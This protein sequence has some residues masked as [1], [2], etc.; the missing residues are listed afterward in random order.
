MTRAPIPAGLK[1]AA[2]RALFWLL[3]AA[4]M[5]VLVLAVARSQPIQ[6]ST[7]TPCPGQP[8]PVVA[9]QDDH[10]TTPWDG[11]SFCP[12][13][14]GCPSRAQ[15]VGVSS[16]VVVAERGPAAVWRDPGGVVACFRR[17]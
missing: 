6:P 17:P 7:D 5:L 10:H 3:I 1:D 14:R 15:G 12:D 4:V 2:W 11:W 8:S 9:W 13:A 16:R